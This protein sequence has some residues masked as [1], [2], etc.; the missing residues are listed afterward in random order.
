MNTTRNPKFPLTT[1]L[2]IGTIQFVG[3]EVTTLCHTTHQQFQKVKHT[4]RRKLDW[5]PFVGCPG[6]MRCTR[7]VGKRSVWISMYQLWHELT[8]LWNIL[9]A[10]V[11][12]YLSQFQQIGSGPFKRG[13]L[14]FQWNTSQSDRFMRKLETEK[15]RTFEGSYWMSHNIWM[16]LCAF[17]A[18]LSDTERASERK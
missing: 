11:F 16:S 9:I 13:T 3:L 14:I 4:F 18:T 10:R 17:L 8:L 15:I 6:R 7:C 5:Q 1:A 12:R 2:A